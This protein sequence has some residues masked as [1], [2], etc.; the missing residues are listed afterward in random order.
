MALESGSNPLTEL[1]PSHPVALDVL[2]TAW[3]SG[4]V[5]A[6]DKQLFARRIS[7][8]IGALVLSFRGSDGVTLLQ[9]LG[10]ALPKLD[11]AVSEEAFSVASPQYS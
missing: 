3:L 5:I 2:S 1:A 8:V 11:P 10:T 6:D 4:M 7:A 9:C